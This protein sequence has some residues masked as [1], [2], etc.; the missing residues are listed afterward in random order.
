MPIPNR[1][2]GTPKDEFLG[3]CIAKLKGEYPLKQATAICYSQMAKERT[4]SQ[5]VLSI[6]NP[7]LL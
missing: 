5:Y 4:N 7:K 3:K 2:K 1:R 6:K